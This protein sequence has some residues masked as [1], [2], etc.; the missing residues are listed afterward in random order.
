MQG[1]WLRGDP[2]GAWVRRL[3]RHA[4]EVGVEVVV[5]CPCSRGTPEAEQ[6]GLGGVRRFRFPGDGRRMDRAL[7]KGGGVQ[8]PARWIDDTCARMGACHPVGGLWIGRWHPNVV[9]ALGYSRAAFEE[10]L[11][12]PTADEPRCEHRQV[13]VG[14]GG[15]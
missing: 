12:R 5:V 6:D 3:A 13:T 4:G 11:T 14:R 1:R 7:S 8:D 9:D 15:P 2:A 10:L